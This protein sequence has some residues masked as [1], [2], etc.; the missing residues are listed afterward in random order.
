MGVSMI[1]PPQEPYGLLM[2]LENARID[3][4]L[5]IDLAQET[6][7]R[8]GALLVCPSTREVVRESI[9]ESLEPRVMQVLVA[10]TRADG[11]VVSR[12]ELIDT[13]WEGRVVGEDSINRVIWRLRKLADSDGAAPFTI[14]TIPRV[15]YRLKSDR[16]ILP[17]D[18][19]EAPKVRVQDFG[20]GR[21]AIV[22]LATAAVILGMWAFW[23][24]RDSTRPVLIPVLS[25]NGEPAFSPDGTMLAYLP[26][27]STGQIFVPAPAGNDVRPASKSDDGAPSWSPDRKRIAY[28]AKEPDGTCRIMVVVL[29]EAKAQQAG[30]CRAAETSSF[31]WQSGTSLYFTD[32]A[33]GLGNAIF[34]LDLRNGKIE[35]MTGRK[36]DS[37]NWP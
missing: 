9:R 28:V 29:K 23:P 6:D 7:F 15:G 3:G 8:L 32:K 18:P 21:G 27:S 25:Q 34:H 17:A 22:S 11:G 30:R 16:V 12:N 19:V 5:T 14:E 33:E 20:W 13:C 26:G 2:G 31:A 1:F 10:L 36:Q 35:R 24:L 4:G 37:T